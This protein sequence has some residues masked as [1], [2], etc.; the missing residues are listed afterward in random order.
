MST[1]WQRLCPTNQGDLPLVLFKYCLTSDG[2]ELYMTDLTNVWSEHLSRQQILKRADENAA[3]IDPSDDSEQYQMLLQKI[4]DAFRNEKDTHVILDHTSPG[5][6]TL[7]LTTSTKL[8][9]PLG[10]LTWTLYLSREP[11]SSLTQHMLLPLIKAEA[12]W[13]SRQQ[14]LM[15]QLKQ[16]D[17]IL[18]KLFDKLEAVG[19]DL[20]TIF[21]GVSGLR[22]G[23]KNATLSQAAK[24]IRG[25]ASFDEHAWLEEHEQ[26]SPG[27]DL[28]ANLL[29]QLLSTSDAVAQPDSFRPP[30][31]RW[32]HAL[33][34]ASTTTLPRREDVGR[35]NE[36][37]P[38]RDDEMTDAATATDTEDDEFERQVTPPKFK[39][40]KDTGNEPFPAKKS[41][42]PAQEPAKASPSPSPRKP[43]TKASIGLGK[44]GKIGK[45][46]GSK[47]ASTQAAR[48]SPSPSP[49][50]E[51]T[52]TSK[53]AHMSPVNN[54][55][56]DSG[57]DSDL[58]AAPRKP[59]PRTQPT[60][61]VKPRGLGLGRIGGQKKPEQKPDSPKSTPSGSPAPEDHDDKNLQPQHSPPPKPRGLGT[62]G[63][64]SKKKEP[65]SSSP[66]NPPH[67]PKSPTSPQTNPATDS[68]PSPPNPKRKPPPAG[69]KKLGVIGGSSKSFNPDTNTNTTST[70][71]SSHRPSSAPVP[72]ADAETETNDELDEPP[73]N[74][75]P[76]RSAVKSPSPD[77]PNHRPGLSEPEPRASEQPPGEPETEEEKANRKR[78]ELKRQLEAKAKAPAKKKR[79]F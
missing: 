19:I 11:Q 30:P 4:G 34:S 35:I 44:I 38:S 72:D 51:P 48:F 18:S 55:E 62:I 54:D 28:A 7:R 16:K 27:S 36:S 45:I 67:A 21:P 10:P 14:N 77:E 32:W 23:R 22:T 69:P 15:N 68:S 33:S 42:E 78:E 52:T 37:Q 61:P 13:E 71:P 6:D 26:S 2:Y 47:V 5:A 24:H 3:T 73:L 50:H 56:T 8:P 31:D 49:D 66:P 20:S 46:G 41:Q 58:D 70:A 43:P 1:K 79:R 63:G 76:T 40:P 53:P 9:K 57:S 29:A 65:P 60:S 64:K 12:D 59:N 25:V 74:P 39:R 17:W 75:K